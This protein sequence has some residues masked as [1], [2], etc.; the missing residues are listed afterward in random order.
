MDS[1]LAKDRLAVLCKI[2]LAEYE[3]AFPR[4]PL[5]SSCW[6]KVHLKRNL[7]EIGTQK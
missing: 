6:D 4:I 2:N 3:I 7:H 1:K 5:S